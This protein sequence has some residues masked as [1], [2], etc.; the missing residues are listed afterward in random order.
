[1]L[2]LL[3]DEPV[4]FVY[5]SVEDAVRD[6]EPPDIESELRAAFDDNAIPYQVEWIRP[7][8]RSRGSFGLSSVD[9]GEYRLVP[10]GP[11]DRAKLLELLEEYE[12][13][14]PPEAE[15]VLRELLGQ[16]RTA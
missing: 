10:A 13:T 15:S 9:F 5:S 16:L 11:P 12:L 4:L 3:M 6:I 8:R 14:D 7:S 1:M 2:I